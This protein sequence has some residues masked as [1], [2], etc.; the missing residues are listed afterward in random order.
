MYK[1]NKTHAKLPPN[2]LMFFKDSKQFK[3]FAQSL[4][5]VTDNKT[6]HSSNK[7]EYRERLIYFGKCGTSLHGITGVFIVYPARPATHFVAG[8][9][10]L[11]HR[12][13]NLI[14]AKKTCQ[15]NGHNQYRARLMIFV[16]A[17]CRKVPQY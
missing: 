16:L 3:E 7:N 5:E 14:F 1:E 8:N 11:T 13:P 6:V 4:P 10:E 17:L 2:D 15:A 9:Y 12:V